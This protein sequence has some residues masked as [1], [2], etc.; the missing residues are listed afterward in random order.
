METP[1]ITPE[2]A[3]KQADKAAQVGLVLDQRD[4][5]ARQVASLIS[6]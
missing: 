3:A 5:Q 6:T 1:A 4:S 2:G